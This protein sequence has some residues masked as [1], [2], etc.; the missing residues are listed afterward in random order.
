[1]KLPFTPDPRLTG[2]A[3]AYRNGM[4]IADSVLPRVPVGTDPFKYLVYNQADRF[5]VPSTLVGRKGKPNQVE[6]GATE[7][8]ASTKDYGL[9]DAVPQH[10]IDRAPE[11]FDPL[12]NAVEG[13]L[14]LVE[15]DREVR[16]ANLV[17][18]DDTYPAAQVETL[19]G[20]DQWS[21]ASS[22]PID[23][24]LQAMDVPLVRPNVLVLGQ[25]TW[26]AL[27]TNPVIVKSFHGNAGDAGVVPRSHVAAL[28]ELEEVLVGPAWLNTARK[29]QDAAFTRVWGKHAAL[30]RRERLA[31][32]QRGVTFG[33]TAQFKDRVAG[34]TE[35]RDIGLRGGQRVRAGESVAEL[36]VAADVGFLF[37]NAVA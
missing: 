30:I 36:I 11:G 9:E 15:L 29:G 28:F 14:D 10:D 23:D 13:I 8:E 33:L 35:D 7:V 25:E 24:I 16:V 27:R 26:T 31:N 20:D 18:D 1:M 37:E 3:I 17:F 19:S 21:H 22:N 12:G 34:S 6:F 32:T 2:I 5:T 4:L